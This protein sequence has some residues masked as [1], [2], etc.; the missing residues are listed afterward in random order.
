[1]QVEH[2]AAGPTAVVRKQ[3]TLAAPRWEIYGDW[4]EDESALETEI[5]YLLV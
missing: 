2:R 1:M 3:T 5:A 4:T